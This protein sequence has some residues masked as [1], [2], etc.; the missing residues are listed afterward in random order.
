LP[1]TGGHQEHAYAVFHHNAK[2]VFSDAL[3]YARVQAV[4]QYLQDVCGKAVDKK[5]GASSVYLTEEQ[6][7]EVM[8]LTTMFLQLLILQICA[9]FGI[10]VCRSGCPG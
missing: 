2:K 6:Y 4:D 9:N 3:S 1:E 5:R 8:Y 7:R 10:Y